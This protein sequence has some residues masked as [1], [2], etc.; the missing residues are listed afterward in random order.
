MALPL[1]L[2][3]GGA[4]LGT[5]GNIIAANKQAQA[6]RDMARMQLQGQ[7]EA[8]A[9]RQRGYEDVRKIQDP[10]MRMGET[11][12]GQLSTMPASIQPGEFDASQ[13]SV[14]SYLDPSMAYQQEQMR[15]QL[16]AS[17]AAGGPGL[18]SGAFAQELQQQAG[19]IAAQDYGNAFGRMQQ[20]RAFSYQDYLNKYANQRQ[21]IQDE[22][23]RWTTLLGS[24]QGAA[25]MT[26]Q[27]RTGVAT[28]Q[29]ESLGDMGAIRG[30]SAAA[31]PMAFASNIQSVTGPQMTTPFLGYLNQTF[32]GP[33]SA[34]KTV[35]PSYAAPDAGGMMQSVEPTSYRLNTLGAPRQGSI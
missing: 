6:T 15:Q 21:A 14:E 12:L 34:P 33:A 20:D 23:G 24:G 8:M 17:A 4:A 30:M 31:G 10:Y 2:A 27:S 26:S 28:Q 1:A 25:N 5:L 7:R 22:M 19:N 9:E 32:G 16:E 29:A 35:A 18:R 13:F 3:A 11:A